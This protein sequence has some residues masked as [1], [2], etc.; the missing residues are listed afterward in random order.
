[1]TTR[2]R[3]QSESV[4]GYFRH[5]ATG[6]TSHRTTAYQ[7]RRTE[8]VVGLGDNQPFL[9]ESYQKS[10]GFL[11]G[12]EW[13]NSSGVE[14]F[15]YPCT[16]QHSDPIAISHLSIDTPSNAAFASETLR[17]TN[18]S[19]ASID[20]MVTAIELREIPGLIK[21]GL[22]VA[23]NRLFKHI[24]SRAFRLLSRAAKINLMIQFGVLP[25]ISDARKALIFQDLV[26]QRVREL[27][28]LQERG[29]R[30]TVDLGTYSRESV[31]GIKYM[32]TAYT[33]VRANMRK[34][35]SITVRG[36]VRW[37]VNNNFYQSD[38]QLRAL[39]MSIVSNNDL[40]VQALY[41]LMPWS[42]L[43][44]YFSNLGDFVSLTRNKINATHGLVRI[45]THTRSSTQ[46]IN[47]DIADGDIDKDVTFSPIRNTMETK[48]RQ[49]VPGG[50]TAQ[51]DFLTGSQLSILGSL[52]V[53]K[54]R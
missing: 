20:A 2:V 14:W 30:R 7:F 17:R 8:D 26:D 28:R 49:I 47:I 52:T 4:Q 10:G 12:R 27:K 37:H 50:L 35:T 39:A 21:E 42:W 19:R 11:K 44:D 53:L 1:M 15:D 9:V 40:D 29:L 41:E 18:P 25:L 46:S 48:R 31:S 23:R 3:A 32:H 33:T 34:E 43:I 24:P 13:S 5:N 54:S 36:H 16:F 22:D 51:V 6:K 45:M 38:A